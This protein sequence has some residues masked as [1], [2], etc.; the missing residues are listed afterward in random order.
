[1]T[2]EELL[3]Q[4]SNISF[5][6]IMKL[7]TQTIP[8]AK[9]YAPWL[10]LSHGV[11]ILENTDELAQYICAYGTM[12]KEKIDLALDSIEDTS[13]F[14]TNELTIV[15][16]GCGQAL[17]TVCFL[18]YLRKLG[19][20][21]TINKIVLIE[22]SSVALGRASLHIEKYV[23]SD[24]IFTINK[25]IND[26]LQDEI[27]Q[28]KG[29]VLHFFSNIL[30][31]PS[32]DICHVHKIISQGVTTNQ[33]FFCVGPQNIGASRIAA[34]GELF[35][36]TSND[37]IEE[38]TGKLSTR[39]TVN[40]LVFRKEGFNTDVV[41][42]GYNHYRQIQD[43]N[44]ILLKRIID[45]IKPAQTLQERVLQF[46]KAVIE[47]ERK[48][49]S[50]IED[51]YIAPLHLE[52][53]EGKSV[54]NVDIQDNPDFEVEFKNN[55]DPK[56]TKWPRNLNIGLGI[57]I[58]DRVYRLLQ[59]VYPHEDLE[60]IDITSQYVQVELSSFTLNPNVADELD[61]SSDVISIIEDTIKE[62][63]ISLEKIENVLQEAIANNLSID[64]NVMLALSNEEIA[65]AQT[66]AELKA[67]SAKD[68]GVLLSSFL[69]GDIED[70]SIANIESDTLLQVEK[71]DESQRKAIATAL[72]SKVSV[73]TG[74]PGTGKT[75]MILNLIVNALVM[76]K[77]VLVASKNNKAV[78]NIKERYD[79]V[80]S[81]G[82]LLRFGSR[83]TVANTLVPYLESLTTRI[84][85]INYDKDSFTILKDHY[86]QLIKKVTDGHKLLKRHNQLSSEICDNEAAL[87]LLIAELNL[88][89]E[90]FESEKSCLNNEYTDYDLEIDNKRQIETAVVTFKKHISYIGSKNSYLSKLFFK[91]FRMGSFKSVVMNDLLN[92]PISV[93]R[94]IENKTGIRSVSDIT[95]M[96]D[97]LS[98]CNTTN[99]VLG[100]ILDYWGNVSR[101]EKKYNTLIADLKRKIEK[102]KQLL[103]QQKSEFSEIE[104]I[105]D[106][107]CDSV[108][109]A[110][111]EIT[112]I[113]KNLLDLVV[114]GYLVSEGSTSAI[115]RYK[116]YLPD[117]I[118]W[119]WEDL[120]EYENNANDFL[121]YF[122]LNAVTSL[123]VKKSYPLMKELFDIVI[124]DEAS[125]CDIAS[126]L[127]LL[128]RAKQ[129][130]VIGDPMQLKH[131]SSINSNEEMSIKEVLSIAE[132]PLVQYANKSLWDYCNELITTSNRNNHS[133][134]LD[135]HYRCHPKIIGYSNERFYRRLGINLSIQTNERHPEIEPQG[136]VW[137]DVVGI[138]KGDTININEAEVKKCIELAYMLAEKYP[139]I[140]IG[141]ISPFRNQAQE[142]NKQLS[143][144][145]G[146]RIVADTVNKF[147]GD[148]R[149][150]IIYSL[151]V[152]DNS[153]ETKIRWIDYGV[154]NLVNV[155]V[156]RARTA[157]YIV[158]NKEYIRKK[159][160]IH[161]PLGYLLN[162]VERA[163][164]IHSDLRTYTYIIDTN[165]FVNCPDIIDRIPARE[166]VIISA[167]VIDELDKLKVTLSGDKKQN[168]EKALRCINQNFGHRKLRMECADLSYLPVDFNRKSPD[169]QILSVV[170]KYRNQNPI[171][172][173]S[174]N[175]LLV[176]AKGLGVKTKTL[177]S[178]LKEY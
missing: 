130:V 131:I 149:D 101:L 128:F 64:R 125:Q 164:K 7:S 94:V 73:I 136:I 37:L 10:G 166:Y 173:S 47:L 132:N 59:Y 93:G 48:K 95:N 144:K 11:K 118:P 100:R 127:P 46:Y 1:M 129:L 4:T 138:Q 15:D 18:D 43:E 56:I 34:F 61:I 26:V 163:S 86:N 14:F 54:I 121:K 33:I 114:Q 20:I 67:M 171:L 147:Q 150:I 157:L 106:Q 177:N 122:R 168:A 79:T 53:N 82:Y 42:V 161:C 92:L 175:G 17:A 30:D 8:D 152:T 12:H 176:K 151:V 16:W 123:S 27:S 98:L 13:I 135:C 110:K 116:S 40:M 146:E 52:D 63:S 49:S 174:D 70:N 87:T 76:G 156:T 25:Y 162:Y 112:E 170:M 72:N 124:I 66:N 24:K 35:S 36:I 158:G 142:I 148:E 89:V 96:V 145:Y 108:K 167:K 139:T 75:Q 91:L 80:D 84:P 102:S 120:S 39:G 105:Y 60:K 57:I 137:E 165:I 6:T 113:G 115:S 5:E 107:I 41:K 103:S 38:H 74:P 111:D 117:N 141:I 90:E 126:A 3:S 2:Y 83:E 50:K 9:K 55:F 71:I 159:S 69:I 29:I 169:N 104:V 88:A 23:S 68:V 134:V 21:P 140:N 160:P 31:V 62:N 153:P 119:R 143:D 32:V 44:S 155:A 65:L 51:S 85:H 172:L 77:S 178:F 133:V 97:L 28:N 81:N 22:P 45:N 99:F 58:D 19:K 109:N 78:D 154:P